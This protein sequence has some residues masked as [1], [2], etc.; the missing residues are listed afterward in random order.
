MY[1]VPRQY[2]HLLHL[3]GRNT[4]TVWPQSLLVSATR[5]SKS[6][7]VCVRCCA[8][9]SRTWVTSS[10]VMVLHPTLLSMMPS[11]TGASLPLQQ[12]S[13]AFSVSFTSYYRRFS[14]DF[15]KI[16]NPLHH[17]TQK[18]TPFIWTDD[19]AAHAFVTLKRLLTSAPVLR[20]PDPTRPF[21]ERFRFTLFCTTP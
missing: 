13:D 21:I 11:E 4:W 9:P 14:Q 6:N 3:S 15:A 1:S 8:H 17:L 2:H 12:K 19:T 5:V 16:A 10:L 7:L 20:Y 18:K